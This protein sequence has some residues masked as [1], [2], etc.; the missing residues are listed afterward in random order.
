MHVSEFK[1]VEGV[2]LVVVPCFVFV[3]E[4]WEKRVRFAS[5]LYEGQSSSIQGGLLSL[6]EG[7]LGLVIRL[8]QHCY[9]I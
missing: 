6:E 9:L 7:C 5:F 3:C 2:L 4:T 1:G 8:A